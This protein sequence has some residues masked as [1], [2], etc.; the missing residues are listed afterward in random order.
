[1][2]PHKIVPIEI[3]CGLSKFGCYFL[4]LFY[5]QKEGVYKYFISNGL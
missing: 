2:N 5:E 1:M 4:I 3:F